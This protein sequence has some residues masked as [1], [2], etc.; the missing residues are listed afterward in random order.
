M[1]KSTCELETHTTNINH[2]SILGT[3]YRR[4]LQSKHWANAEKGSAEE[5]ANINFLIATGNDAIRLL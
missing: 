3:E 5:L 1:K 2:Y 4:A